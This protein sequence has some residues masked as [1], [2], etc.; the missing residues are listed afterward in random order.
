MNIT[1]DAKREWLYIRAKI[2]IIQDAKGLP[3]GNIVEIKKSKAL[4]RRV[5]NKFSSK[6]AL[7]WCNRA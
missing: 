5:G 6:R 7:V 4:K 2:K 3:Y 1:V